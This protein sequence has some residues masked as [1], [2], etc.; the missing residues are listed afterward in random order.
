MRTIIV[1]YT[2]ANQE[3]FFFL[4]YSSNAR[5]FELPALQLH[6][7]ACSLSLTWLLRYPLG[8]LTSHHGSPDQ[9]LEKRK[10]RSAD[11]RCWLAS[12]SSTA[13][14][15]TLSCESGQNQL[16]LLQKKGNG[17]LRFHLLPSSSLTLSYLSLPPASSLSHSPAPLIHRLPSGGLPGEATFHNMQAFPLHLEVSQQAAYTLLLKKIKK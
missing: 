8:G 3:L 16:S 13:L 4:N 15:S 5:L 9:S 2:K 14:H 10:I 17:P 1:L 7:K 12:S 11:H 6:V